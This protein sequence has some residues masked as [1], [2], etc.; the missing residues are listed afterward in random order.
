MNGNPS[1]AAICFSKLAIIVLL[2]ITMGALSLAGCA[3]GQGSTPSQQ[4]ASSETTPKPAA[5]VENLRVTK[6]KDSGTILFDISIDDFNQSGFA[7]G[8][9]VNIMFSNGFEMWG[10]PYYNGYY[11]DVDEMLLVAY[12]SS[13]CI[14]ALENYSDSL[15]STSG[16]TDGDTATIS[17]AEPGAYL[18]VQEALDITYTN[19]RSDYESDEQFANFRTS[20]GGA[21]KQGVV[22]RSASPIDNSYNRAPYVEALMKQAAVAY[23]LDLSDSSDEADALIA[24][25][26]EQGIDVSYFEELYT[27]DRVATLNLSASYPS[28]DFARSLAGGLVQ[29]SQHEGPYLAHCV[30]GKDRTGFV[31]MLLQAL[32]GASY[33]EMLT[34][35]MITYDNYYGITQESDPSKYDAISNLNLDGMLWFLAG[36]DDV[37]DLATVDYAESARN[38]LKNGGMT[39]EQID[40]LVARLTQ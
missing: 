15:W 17:L 29:M 6:D 19:E 26:K 8:D 2:V 1:S 28:D 38:Y 10:I 12:P 40:A 24:E 14:K 13:S 37:A 23:V 33:D 7:Y 22:Y 3:N 31:C 9:S 5:S 39:D 34:D 27:T 32:C 36:D 11:G 4:S 25:D 18:N 20:V 35:Y 21:L 30:E 16:L